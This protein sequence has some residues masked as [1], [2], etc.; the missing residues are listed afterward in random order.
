M[1]SRTLL[2]DFSKDLDQLGTALE[3]PAP[4]DM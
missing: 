3:Q 2:A 1:D 4:N